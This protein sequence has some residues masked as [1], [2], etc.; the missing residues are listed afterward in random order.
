MSG[1]VIFPRV[2][3]VQAEA[4][5]E[6]LRKAGGTSVTKGAEPDSYVITGHGVKVHAVYGDKEQAVAVE[7]ISKPFF[8]SMD[9]I[10]SQIAKA[11]QAAATS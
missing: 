4:M 1:T 11:L 6:E 8:V 7:V 3:R 5:L 10:H 2:T 9:A